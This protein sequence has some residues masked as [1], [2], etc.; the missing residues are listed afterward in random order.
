MKVCINLNPALFQPTGVGVYAL[1]LFIHLAQLK[2]EDLELYGLSSSWKYRLRIPEVAHTRLINS[3]IPSRIFNYCVHKIPL[4]PVEILTLKKL[5]VVHSTYGLALPALKAKKVIT[6]HDLYFLTGNGESILSNIK[7]DRKAFQKSVFS[8]DAIIC[9]SQYTRKRLLEIF[10]EA[11]NKTEVIYSGFIQSP[12]I[13]ADEEQELF[14]KKTMGLPDSYVVFVG[15]IEKRKN[16]LSLVEAIK[17]LHSR[18]SKINLIL[19]GKAGYEGHKVMQAIAGYDFIHY[20]DYVE[21][22]QKNILYKYA[23]LM[24]MPSLEEGFGL[25]LL[26]AMSWGVPVIAARGSALEEIAAQAAYY[27]EE[28]SPEGISFAINVVHENEDL[29]KNLIQKGYNRITMFNWEETASKVYDVYRKMVGQ[30]NR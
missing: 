15:T 16:L 27:M 7:V 24:V 22:K 30:G 2:K 29:R 4:L 5:D 9:V 6:V 21:E 23:R 10:P 20:Y 18:G 19:A 25:P 11:A 17:I 14:E 3:K 26:E 8:T 28:N 12:R 13:H 1:E